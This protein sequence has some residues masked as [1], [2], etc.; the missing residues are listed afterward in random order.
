MF[1]WNSQAILK[2]L[3]ICSGRILQACAYHKI[4]MVFI[5]LPVTV[6]SR[7]NPGSQKYSPN[8]DWN[9]QS[10]LLKVFGVSLEM[11][12]DPKKYFGFTFDQF[13]ELVSVVYTAKNCLVIETTNCGTAGQGWMPDSQKLSQNFHW[14][15]LSNFLMV[16]EMS[17]DP[18]RYSGFTFDEFTKLMYTVKLFGFWLSGL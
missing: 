10:D 1:V 17:S 8:S 7:Q 9:P 18:K 3:W 15:I 13:I 11:S 16:L 5:R 14:K 4:T 2:L 6:S 12:S